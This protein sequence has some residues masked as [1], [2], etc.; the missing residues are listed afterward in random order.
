MLLRIFLSNYVTFFHYNQLLCKTVFSSDW[1]K[2]KTNSIRMNTTRK[3]NFI[4]DGCFQRDDTYRVNRLSFS[5]DFGHIGMFWLTF[6]RK[7][8]TVHRLSD[9]IGRWSFRALVDRHFG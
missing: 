9:S 2:L 4:F 3:I 8:A 6:Q 7:R 1:T 5:I